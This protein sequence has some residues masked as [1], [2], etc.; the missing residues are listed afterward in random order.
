MPSYDRTRSPYAYNMQRRRAGQDP[1]KV[2]TKYQ[3]TSHFSEALYVV[4]K[5]KNEFCL[6][7]LSEFIW[8]YDNE[9]EATFR[10]G[11]AVLSIERI[12]LR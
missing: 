9:C 2:P 1:A 5:K 12:R 7:I 11:E 4:T 3:K 8:D 10:H 6:K